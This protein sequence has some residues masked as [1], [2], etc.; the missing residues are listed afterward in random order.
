MAGTAALCRAAVRRG[1]IA[2]LHHCYGTACMCVCAAGQAAPSG[3]GKQARLL[4]AQPGPLTVR[5]SVRSRIECV[6]CLQ[7]PLRLPMPNAGTLF[8]DGATK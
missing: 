2:V 6:W 8:P 4:P 5:I 7:Q 1:C 3:P